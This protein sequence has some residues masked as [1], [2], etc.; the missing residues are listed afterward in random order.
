MNVVTAAG[1]LYLSGL[2]LD[3]VHAQIAASGVISYL[4]DGLNSTVALTNGSGAIAGSYTYSPYGDSVGGGAG[5]TAP[6]QFT[7]REDDAGTGL[8]YYRARYYSPQLSRFI[9]EDPLGLSAGLNLYAYVSGNPISL[10]DPR[11]LYDLPPLEKFIGELAEA[12][13]VFEPIAT[14]LPVVGAVVLG[15]NVGIAVDA[16]C[17]TCEAA[18]EALGGAIYEATHPYDPNDGINPDSLTDP[19]PKFI[20]PFSI[21]NTFYPDPADAGC[22]K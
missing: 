19:A 17:A 8:Y 10:I 13:D 11:G 15:V 7:G 5:V 1:N 22:S 16:T 14:A 21:E 4:R 6:F 9:S 3:D 20:D 18:A 12:T 2:G